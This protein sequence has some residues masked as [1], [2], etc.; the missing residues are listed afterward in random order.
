VLTGRSDEVVGDEH[1]AAV[2]EGNT[3]GPA[4][5]LIQNVPE[6]Q[7]LEQGADDEDGPPIRGITDLGFSRVAGFDNRFPGKQSAEL[8]EYLDKEILASEVGENALLDLAALAVGFNDANVFV[9]GAVGGAN[10]DGSGI[11]ACDYHDTPQRMP[12]IT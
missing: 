1:E 10:F 4:E 6:A 9:D 8:G 5:V 11:H 7:L 3:S 2:G 12:R